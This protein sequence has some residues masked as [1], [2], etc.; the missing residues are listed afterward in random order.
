MTDTA[1]PAGPL[2]GI[3][4]L[5]L[6]RI[7]AG[8]SATQV[9]GDLGADVI[10][11]ERPGAGDDTRKW[12]PPYLKDATGKDTTESAYYLSA[13]RNKRSVAIDFSKPEGA[14]LLKR[15]LRDCDVLFENYKTGG[16]AKYGL[17]WEQLRDD[18]PSLVYVSLT[19]FGQTGPYRKRAGYDYLA[20]AM[21]GIMSITGEPE[22]EPMK[23]GV[24]ISDLMAGMYANVALLAALRHRDATGE[25]Q[26][27][28]TALLDTQVAWLSYEAENFL[29]SGERPPRRGNAHPNIVPYQTFAASDG[30]FILG[31]GNDAQF[32]RFCEL[33]GLDELAADP[34]FATNSARSVNRA[35]LIPV[36]ARRIARD[37]VAFWLEG[38]EAR[39]VPASP[40]NHIDEVFEDPQVIA[41]GMKVEIEHPAHGG[42]VPFVASPMK[43][44][45]T[46]PAY[47]RPPPMLGEHTEE[48]LAEF[49]L[50][51]DEIA[52]LRAAGVI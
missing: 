16:L 15:L 19:G 27:I 44:S 21:G 35:E 43:L 12:G 14:A 45:A 8:P 29:I 31:V 25:G 2:A 7:L 50:T 49:G 32:A 4:I 3:R 5:D 26:R 47:R 11:I 17:A 52:G 38:L 48:V 46:P 9:L 33:A 39:K 24:G 37:P 22:G 34:R 23:I 20:Q 36:L 40:I 51:A 42:P 28:D 30:H 18:F 6:T 41:R 1:T 13:N 10:K